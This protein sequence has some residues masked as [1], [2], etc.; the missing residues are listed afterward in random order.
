MHKIIDL[1][2]GIAAGC[3]PQ[4][5]Y[6]CHQRVHFREALCQDCHQKLPWNKVACRQCALP[7]EQGTLCGVCATDPPAFSRCI[8]PLRYEPPVSDFIVQLKFQQQL[9]YSHVLGRLLAAAVGEA[10]SQAL[11]EYLIPVP[12]HYK[13]LRERGFNQAMEIAKPISRALRIPVL[14]NHCTRTKSTLPQSRLS[15]SARQRNIR[16]AFSIKREIAFQH[17][18]IVDDVMTTGETVRVFSQLLAEHGVK[19]IEVWCCARVAA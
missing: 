8:A 1:I 3:F 18:A 7:L 14:R 11:P 10:N 13:R 6:L 17:V 5:C 12:L 19:N 16:A 15:A 9:R 4:Y 2:T